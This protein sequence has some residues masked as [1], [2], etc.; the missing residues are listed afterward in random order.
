MS[1]FQKTISLGLFV[2]LAVL[3]LGSLVY[4]EEVTLTI[5][6]FKYGEVEGAQPVM[7]K[8]DE[9]FMKAYP[10]I[11]IDHQAQPFNDGQY[12]ELLRAA[13]AAN[14]GPDIALFHS[15]RSA[16]VLAEVL[17][18]L[19]DYIAPWRD[20]I[21]EFSWK[22]C[23]VNQNLE[24]GIILM[25]ITVQGFGI[26]Y[27]KS[28]FTQAGLDPDTP[29]KDYE[30]FIK[31][32]EAL[33][34]AG[35]VPMLE[36]RKGYPKSVQYLGRMLVANAYPTED[37]LRGLMEGSTNFTDPEFVGALKLLE[38]MRAKGYFDPEA[39]GLS[40][41]GD[42]RPKFRAGK[43]AMIYGLLSDIA[44]WKEF[45]DALGKDNVGFFPNV[46]MPGQSV[47]DRLAFQGA[48]I[49]YGVFTW[50]K[51][52]DAAVEYAEFYARE[53][54]VVLMQDLGALVPN[55]KLELSSLDYPVLH[56]ILEYVKTTPTAT[57]DRFIPGSLAKTVEQN[58][59]ALWMNGEITFDEYIQKLQKELEYA[60]EDQ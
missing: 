23:A 15:G 60:R 30:S 20:E 32:C 4:A 21:T 41:W 3:T 47:K 26:Y 57:Y 27:N 8:I 58:Q 37:R 55:T 12:Y 31:A 16:T 59:S 54:A 13:A 7:K 44:H 49:G 17:V 1:L 40:Y 19:D 9:M 45:S 48:G 56:D 18:R 28:L 42:V 6:D 46:N 39:S 34:S 24:E 53:G 11:K 52:Q 35:I 5:W 43:G 2:G 51:H 38:E 22:A 25:P 10:D 33:K 50:S 36:Q 14:E 29:P